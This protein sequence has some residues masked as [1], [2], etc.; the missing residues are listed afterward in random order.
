[1]K[2]NKAY[3]TLKTNILYISV[4]VCVYGVDIRR[5]RYNAFCES[6]YFAVV[7]MYNASGYSFCCFYYDWM[8]KRNT[9]K[10]ATKQQLVKS[11]G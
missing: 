4:C 9:I 2:K 10:H 8:S 1:M 6:I 5:W 7:Y 3:T 11:V